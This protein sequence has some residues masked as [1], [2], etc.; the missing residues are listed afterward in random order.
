MNYKLTDWLTANYKAG[1]NT[2][3]DRRQTTIS[4]SSAGAGSLGAI[5]LDN[6]NF[7]E[8]ESNFFLS[9]NNKLSSL[10]DLTVTAG[11]NYNQRTTERNATL[12]SEILFFGIDNINLT[13]TQTKVSGITPFQKRRIYGIYGDVTLGFKSSVFL[14]L[15]ARNDWSSTLPANNRSFLYPSASLSWNFTDDI[16]VNQNILSAG[17]IRGS[18][19]RVGRDADPYSLFSIY[20][21]NPQIVN[22][23][24]HRLVLVSFQECTIRCIIRRNYL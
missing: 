23:L 24:V 4:N 3:N 11:I 15:T 14:N 2:Y 12:G 16:K 13:N 1:M 17:K 19:S 5:L 8:L 6:I 18:I 10:L 21:I 7:Q 22:P 9:S 20:N